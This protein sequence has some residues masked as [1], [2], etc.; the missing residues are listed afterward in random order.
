[1]RFQKRKSASVVVAWLI[2]WAMIASACAEFTEAAAVETTP[3]PPSKSIYAVVDVGDGQ[4]QYMTT[5]EGLFA[6]HDGGRSW[7]EVA[8]ESMRALTGKKE[9]FSIGVNPH[10]PGILLVGNWEG[11]WKSHDR[12]TTWT[13]VGVD[14]PT[15]IVAL[16][17][18]FNRSSPDVVYMGTNGFGVYRSVDGGLTW[19][20]G[21]QGLPRVADGRRAASIHTVVAD[22]TNLNIAYAASSLSGVFSTLDGG[23]T[24]KAIN[25]GLPVPL[26]RATFPPRITISPVTPHTLYLAL[27]VP[28]HSHLT[29]T[30]IFAKPGGLSEGR[31]RQIAELSEK[32][33]SIDSIRVTP[34][35]P[36]T[37]HL[38]SGSR[39]FTVP[40]V[41]DET[42]EGA[43]EKVGDQLKP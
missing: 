8:I 20:G 23:Q 39:L 12:G 35:E 1:M 11:L 25:Q 40:A 43:I 21:D 22:P 29:V 38:Q 31:W 32:N 9:V 37:L 4:N 28:Y 41:A 17:L 3:P 13:Q 42:P 15:G 14:L 30:Q 27:G 7:A 10:D 26:P 6:S 5:S 36:A 19:S 16:S 18:S 33:I 2:A 24:W 34:G